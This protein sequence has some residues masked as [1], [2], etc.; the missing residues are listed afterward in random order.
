RRALPPAFRIARR[1]EDDGV[2]VR[3]GQVGPER[4][5]R[6]VDRG[7]EVAEDRVPVDRRPFR[8]LLPQRDVLRMPEHLEHVV[9]GPTQEPLEDTPLTE[10]ELRSE[11]GDDV[12][13]IV[14]ACSDTMDHEAKAPWRERKTAYLAHLASAPD[15]ALLVI[16]ADKL[17][18]ARSIATDLEA[19]GP[20]L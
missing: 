9:A 10:P 12:A 16:V 2:G 8:R 11:F 6:P 5:R 4:R 17:H 18:N 3:L 14:V 1:Q 13:A 20:A 15:E 7:V 19:L